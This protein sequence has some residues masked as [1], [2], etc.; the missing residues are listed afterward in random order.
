MKRLYGNLPAKL[1][2]LLLCLVS[3]IVSAGGI[4][5]MIAF[6]ISFSP[7]GGTVTKEKLYLNA[8][9]L[10]G[11]T[12]A[13]SLLSRFS[14]DPDPKDL[15]L[16][17]EINMDYAVIGS[18]TQDFDS[19]DLTD[20]KIYLYKSTNYNGYDQIMEGGR[21]WIYIYRDQNFLQAFRS[22]VCSYN[23][24][25]ESDEFKGTVD[26][27]RLFSVKYFWILYRMKDSFIENQDLF[28][29]ARDTVD[30]FWF[31]YELLVPGTVISFLILLGSG[32][33]LLL[34]AGHRSD[35]SELHRR[36]TDRVPFILLTAGVFLI[37]GLFVNAGIEIGKRLG[38]TDLRFILFGICFTAAG[39]GLVLILYI[40][41]I[42]VRI[43]THTFWES[44]LLY[45]IL[46][47]LK[48]FT[49]SVRENIPLTWS[50]L[51]F[52]GV[53]TLAEAYVISRTAYN[54]SQEELAFLLY[55]MI[56]VPFTLMLVLQY[57]RI[58]R[59]TKA[60]IEGDLR[61]PIDTKGMYWVFK[62][63]AEDI[64]RIQAGMTKAVE[65]RMKSERLKT[66]LITN[67]SHDI[68]TPLTS[69]INYTD[70]IQKEELQSP[71]LREY[72][73]VLARQADRLKK[74]IVDLIEASKASTGNLDIQMENCDSSV[75]LAQAVAEFD[76]KLKQKN[77][78]IVITQPDQRAA[79]W[80]DGRYLW[81]IFENLLSNICKYAL[82]GTRVY[83]DIL[84][85][86]QDVTIIFK[87]ISGQPLN[88]SGEELIER[89]VRGDTSRSVEG[90]GLG[91]SIAGSLA[92]L[93]EG[94]LTL[95]V[96]GD[97]FKVTLVF[98]KGA[99]R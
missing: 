82:E 25:F 43:K 93:M 91:L 50:V 52:L 60:I 8:Y 48:R 26:N 1:I 68:K 18:A 11:Q 22:G 54:N 65:E 9:Q 56:A 71:V 10:A 74:L 81:R 29:Q 85:G 57:D 35:S 45:R 19:L 59:R 73:E 12:Y 76:D 31:I 63:H 61:T 24:G 38:Y 92:A 96:D 84:P 94:T 69:I 39:M 42:A 78:S 7:E 36:L 98:Q 58:K 87:N 28:I 44:T 64:N 14:E 27:K 32:F 53:L 6:S 97:L 13:A 51:T 4:L 33:C 15:E 49:A 3:G 34:F 70:L 20:D 23:K 80:A 40:M 86:D 17:G 88:I 37:E 77:L 75:I 83:I 62:T 5:L 41:S 99:N 95:E 55:K 90:S 72:I 47:M 89:F 16:Q 79:L 67:V 66:E 21:H 46:N 2:A 30:C